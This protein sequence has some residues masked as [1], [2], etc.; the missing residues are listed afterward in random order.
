MIKRMFVVV[1]ML[2]SFIA[3]PGPAP[4]IPPTIP[5]HPIMPDL[6]P[7]CPHSGDGDRRPTPLPFPPPS[8]EEV[9]TNEEEV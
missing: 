6:E 9:P 7:M 3:I 1:M 2:A 8:N 5:Q 4:I